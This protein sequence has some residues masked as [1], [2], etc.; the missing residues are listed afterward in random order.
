MKLKPKTKTMD[1]DIIK[2]FIGEMKFREKEQ[3]LVETEA[4]INATP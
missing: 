3:R 4:R 2:A 1:I